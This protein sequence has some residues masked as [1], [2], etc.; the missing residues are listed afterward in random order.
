[1]AN[2]NAEIKQQG[3]DDAWFTTNAAVVYPANIVI[4]HIDGRYKFTDGVT[5]LSALSFLGGSSL[6]ANTLGATVNGA[7]TAIP[8]DTDLVM[9]VDTSVAKKNTW[10][11]IKSF[12]KTYFD[13]IY[14]NTAAV[15]NQIT[16][17]LSGYE[18]I[19]N[20]QT[21]LTASTTK[22]PTVN[23]VNTG[24]SNKQDTLVS[25]TN[26]K[27]ING[28]SVLGSGDLVISGGDTY[29]VPL[30]AHSGP[31]PVDATTYYW[32]YN[33]S[34]YQTSIVDAHG[35]PITKSGTITAC[36]LTAHAFSVTGTLENST[37]SLVVRRNGVT[38]ST[39]QISNTIQF[40]AVSKFYLI[41]GLSIAVQAGDRVYGKWD[42][43]TWVTN[44][45]AAWIDGAFLVTI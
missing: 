15:A 35:A 25:G 9:S 34:N 1:M 4:Y 38:I 41:T 28:S 36:D 30:V 33:L 10:T 21:D 14:T 24:L 37:V 39:N 26:I 43:P 5:A 42:T 32:G 45:T 23:A 2:I 16:T 12:L 11:Q 27:T 20:K 44:P 13:S 17:A 3:N 19:S 7:V 31:N 8:N 22:Y 6:D 18:L 29:Q 40:G